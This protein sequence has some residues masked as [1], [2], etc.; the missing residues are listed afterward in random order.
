[1]NKG[2]KSIYEINKESTRELFDDVIY[3]RGEEYKQEGC[4]RSIEAINATTLTGIVQG[5]QKYMV[6]ITIDEEGDILCNC[7]CPCDFN[8]KHAAAILLDWISSKECKEKTLHKSNKEPIETLDQVLTKK[9]K[10]DLI[11]LMKLFI[12]RYPELTLYLHVDAYKLILKIH[13]L[14]YEDW[15]WHNIDLLISELEMI[16]QGIQTNK[17]QWNKKLIKEMKTA[18][19]IMIDY[20]GDINDNGQLAF[21]LDEWFLTYGEIVASKNPTKKQKME[22]IK[23]IIN[24]IK[25]DKIGLSHTIQ[26]ALLGMCSTE[27]DIDLINAQLKSIEYNDSEFDYHS[28]LIINMYDKIGMNEKYIQSAIQSG[29]EIKA[30]EKLM[31]VK[32]FDE[33]LNLCEHS[34]NNTIDLLS[35]KAAIL[36]ELGRTQ[37]YHQCI[38]QLIQETGQYSY[39]VQLKQKSTKKEWQLYRDIIINDAKEKNLDMFLSRLYYD[40]GDYKKAYEFSD[41]ITDD[42]YL[43]LLAKKLSKTNPELSC[44]ILRNLCFDF[45]KKGSG[46]PY[47]KT[48]SLLKNMKRI[49]EAGSFFQE[50]KRQLIEKHKKKYSLMKI[51]KNI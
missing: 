10:D 45:V 43:E 36:Q 47:K 14:F 50:T 13:R 16:L 23:T 35:K 42:G 2:I 26:Q 40:E 51:I 44:R 3:Y 31:Q 7:S 17:N 29:Q 22:F 48:G 46:W 9:S 41:E 28:N 6:S 20:N 25:E 33:A 12:E 18:S 19:Q 30:I 5:N 11:L 1:M 37:E 4:V 38:L 15:N 39:A 21:F 32:R 27:K 24:W 34:K 49:D 8:C